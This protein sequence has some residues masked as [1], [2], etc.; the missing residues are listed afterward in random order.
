MTYAASAWASYPA[1]SIEA[2][3]VL[4]HGPRRLRLLT[5]PYRHRDARPERDRFVVGEKRTRSQGKDFQR[6]EG[7]WPRDFRI[8]GSSA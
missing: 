4:T 1:Q 5:S 2:V 7:P 6:P 3:Q 8:S